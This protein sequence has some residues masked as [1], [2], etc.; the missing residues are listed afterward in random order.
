MARSTTDIPAALLMLETDLALSSSS[1][2]SR[3]SSVASGKDNDLLEALRV[4][5]QSH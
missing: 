4:Y 3:S 5:S 1:P 2:P